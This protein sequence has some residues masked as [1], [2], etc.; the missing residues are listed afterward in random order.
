MPALAG[1]ASVLRIYRSIFAAQQPASPACRAPTAR[2]GPRG[3]STTPTRLQALASNHYATLGVPQTADSGAIKGAYYRLAKTFHPDLNKTSGASDKF[4]AV[5]TAYDILS[6]HSKRRAYDR[7]HMPPP[8]APAHRATRSNTTYYDPFSFGDHRTSYT[9]DDLKRAAQGRSAFSTADEE[10][11]RNMMGEDDDAEGHASSSSTFDPWKDS[12]FAA[13][14]AAFT[15]DAWGG[16]ARSAAEQEFDEFL[17]QVAMDASRLKMRRRPGGWQYAPNPDSRRSQRRAEARRIRKFKERPGSTA[18]SSSR[19]RSGHGPKAAVNRA[20]HRE[21]DSM[22]EARRQ[23][24]NAQEGNGKSRSHCDAS[25][26]VTKQAARTG[27][28]LHRVAVKVASSAG[29]ECALCHGSGA[30]HGH[31]K[32]A[33]CGRCRGKG[34]VVVR[35]VRGEKQRIDCL[36]CESTGF[37]AKLPRPSACSGC[38]GTGVAHGKGGRGDKMFIRVK[39]PPGTRD[40]DILRVPIGKGGASTARIQVRVATP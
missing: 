27:T 5:Q 32:T 33:K 25:V 36:V 11:W 12:E 24:R 14:Y 40:Q 34:Y 2:L 16:R 8:V 35:S 3:F 20:L 31:V 1:S 4:L 28:V 18:S 21:Q 39:V 10:T 7:T 19:S 15:A 9:Y 29:M 22:A 13:G 37:N 6:D 26:T 30:F 17:A 38:D 23:R